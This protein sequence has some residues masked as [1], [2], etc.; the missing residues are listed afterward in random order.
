M[1]D[2][3]K[4]MIK[5]AGGQWRLIYLPANLDVIRRRLRERNRR[6]DA[7]ALTVT[8]RMLDEFQTRWAPPDG[9][10]EEIVSA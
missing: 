5:D 7:N 9:E 8:E 2:R 1:G 4:H 6:T 3:C 10:G